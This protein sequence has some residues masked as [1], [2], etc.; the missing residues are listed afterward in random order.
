MTIFYNPVF[1]DLLAQFYGFLATLATS[2]AP[3][4]G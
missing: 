2:C 4:C 3:S 1:Y